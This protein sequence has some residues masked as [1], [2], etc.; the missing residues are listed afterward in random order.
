MKKNIYPSM[1]RLFKIW[2]SPSL[3]LKHRATGKM[4]FYWPSRFNNCLPDD[5][6]IIKNRTD[7]NLYIKKVLE[8]DFDEI[9]GTRPY[10]FSCSQKKKIKFICSVM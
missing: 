1:E 2:L 10:L 8:I 3:I 9:F 5:P 4:I 7:F 6:C